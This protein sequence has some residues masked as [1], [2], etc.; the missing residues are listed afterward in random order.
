MRDECGTR[1]QH[2]S[3]SIFRR[4]PDN[5]GVAT[6]LISAS[7]G[8]ARKWSLNANRCHISPCGSVTCTWWVRL[9]PKGGMPLTKNIR[10][11][12]GLC[13]ELEP[14]GRARHGPAGAIRRFRY[15]NTPSLRGALATKQSIYPL[16]RAMDCFASLAMAVS[17][18]LLPLRTLERPQQVALP[19]RAMPIFSLRFSTPTA[20]ITT[21]LPIT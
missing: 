6:S 20:P 1:P 8:C 15:C 10:S 9:D 4:R 3:N 16:C 11:C 5:C 12:F 7:L 17:G 2:P 13:R 14:N 18:G 21:C 19:Q